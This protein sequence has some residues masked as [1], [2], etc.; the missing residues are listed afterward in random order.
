M[1]KIGDR[2]TTKNGRNIGEVAEVRGNVVCV[3]WPNHSPKFRLPEYQMWELEV[4][5]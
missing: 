3:R 1:I 4:V 2:I 5:S